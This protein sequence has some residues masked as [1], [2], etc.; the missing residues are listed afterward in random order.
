VKRTFIIATCAVSAFCAGCSD[1]PTIVRGTAVDHGEALFKDPLVAKTSFNPFSCA[2]CHDT[3]PDRPQ[4]GILRPGA[5]LGGVTRRPSYWGGQE[6]DL[7]RAINQCL[8]YFMLKDKPWSAEDEDAEAM[9]AY[10][11]S[12]PSGTTGEQAVPFT[13]VVQ[14]DDLPAGDT[15][16]GATIFDRACKACHGAAR[17]GAGRLADWMPVLPDQTLADH[18]EYTELDRRLTF[19][20]KTRHGGFLG[21]SGQMPPFSKELLSG[22][23]MG[24]LLAFFGVY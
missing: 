7:L 24:D 3:T 13:V 4:G 2:T 9:Y 6:L 21:Y 19:V 11:D 12:L 15:T 1:E 22:E 5:P 10:L 16:R 20:E 14:I 8:Y 17:T 18:A 23:D